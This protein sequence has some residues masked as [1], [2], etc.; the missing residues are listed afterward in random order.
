MIT[1][2]TARAPHALPPRR[3]PWTLLGCGQTVGD[4]E[5]TIEAVRLDELDVMPRKNID[6]IVQG[7][8]VSDS[9][10]EEGDESAGLGG[11]SPPP[12]SVQ[13]LLQFGSLESLAESWNDDDAAY[14][15]ICRRLGRPL[16]KPM[17]PNK[18]GRQ[19]I[20]SSEALGELA[21]KLQCREVDGAVEQWLCV[22][23][24]LI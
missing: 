7:G 8:N 18:R 6:S 12:P 5:D 14:H 1:H 20:A 22:I 9:E 23:L 21:S 4:K 16:S 19:T 2:C 3:L 10:H 17:L 13:V 24:L 11:I 15:I